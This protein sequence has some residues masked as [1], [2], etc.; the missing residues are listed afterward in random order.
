MFNFHRLVTIVRSSL[1]IVSAFVMGLAM[2]AV[3]HPMDYGK[4]TADK[5][6]SFS[7]KALRHEEFS[8]TDYTGL[9]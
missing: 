6:C 1:F 5:R 3:R 7:T 2:P 9:V 8:A 4:T